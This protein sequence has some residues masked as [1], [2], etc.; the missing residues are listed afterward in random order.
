MLMNDK[1]RLNN[2][3]KD[4]ISNSVIKRKEILYILYKITGNLYEISKGIDNKCIL[5]Y[6]YG[7]L[8]SY[9]LQLSL[10]IY[11]NY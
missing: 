5:E 6:K 7:E 2:E 10:N 9:I 4:I 11:M 8:L 1:D 3:V